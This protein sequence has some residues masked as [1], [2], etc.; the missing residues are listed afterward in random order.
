[1]FDAVCFSHELAVM[2][3]H[4]ESYEAVLRLLGVPAALTAFVGDGGSDELLGARRTG[5]GLVVFARGDAH[6]TAST[7]WA[8]RATT[9]ARQAD[10]TIGSLSQLAPLLACR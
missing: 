2:K 10:A 5:F 1:M 6:S 4:P 8:E 3:P 7:R 9:L